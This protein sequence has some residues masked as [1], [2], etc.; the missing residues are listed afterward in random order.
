[1]AAS[2]LL[3]EEVSVILDDT[4]VFYDDERLENTMKW[5]AEHKQGVDFHLSEKRTTNIEKVRNRKKN[6]VNEN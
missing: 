1:M 4:F 3:H 6:Y 5:L 2:E